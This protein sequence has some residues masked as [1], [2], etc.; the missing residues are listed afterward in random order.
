MFVLKN[1]NDSELSE[2]NSHARLSHA[3]ELLKNV[4]IILFTA[5]KLFILTTPPNPQNDRLCGHLST[6]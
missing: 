1:T 4:G 3:K 6:I 5:E 2:A